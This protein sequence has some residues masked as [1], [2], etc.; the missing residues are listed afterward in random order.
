MISRP[1]FGSPAEWVLGVNSEN[2]GAVI[3][4]CVNADADAPAGLTGE[5]GWLNAGAGSGR[6]VVRRADG[7]SGR[8]PARACGDGL[9]PGRLARFGAPWRAVRPRRS[10][11]GPRGPGSSP[12][13]SVGCC[14]RSGRPPPPPPPPPPSLSP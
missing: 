10:G 4:N 5:A 7:G 11:A 2:V 8:R 13:G 3:V 9:Q 6:L 1:A 14:P 12:A